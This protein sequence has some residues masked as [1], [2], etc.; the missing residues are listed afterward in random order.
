MV[1]HDIKKSNISEK[2]VLTVESEKYGNSVTEASKKELIINASHTSLSTGG[3][4]VLE[5]KGSGL[6]SPEIIE[7]I[8][9]AIERVKTYPV[10]ARRRGIEGT[11]YVGFRIGPEGD[12]MEIEILKSSGHNIL[13]TA[14]LNVVKKAAPYPYIKSRVE[15]P[16]IYRLKN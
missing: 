5:D 8:G 16:I 12:P 2:T 11:V 1:S 13:D 15:V 10:L 14:T 4:G 9:K 3:A 7:L 6:L